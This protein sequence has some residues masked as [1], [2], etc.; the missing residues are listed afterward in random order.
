MVLRAWC[1]KMFVRLKLE[2]DSRLKFGSAIEIQKFISPTCLSLAEKILPFFKIPDLLP[3]SCALCIDLLKVSGIPATKTI[4]NAAMNYLHVIPM[5]IPLLELISMADF[6]VVGLPL[7]DPI[8]A[9]QH[10]LLHQKL[11]KISTDETRKEIKTVMSITSQINS[12]NNGELP[13]DRNLIEFCDF[14]KIVNRESSIVFASH[15]CESVRKSFYTYALE[16]NLNILDFLDPLLC[17]GLFD[18]AVKNI[19]L[20]LVASQFPSLTAVHLTNRQIAHL[21][22]IPMSKNSALFQSI[23]DVID[24]SDDFTLVCSWLRFMYHKE[25]WVRDEAKT[26]LSDIFQFDF[27][28]NVFNQPQKDFY[29]ETFLN[30]LKSSTQFSSNTIAESLLEIII[31]DDQ[32]IDIKQIS[33]TRLV[34][35]ILDPYQDL[36][37]IIPKLYNLSFIDFPD[38]LHAIS[39][40]DGN[41][42]IDKTQKL[43]ELVKLINEDNSIHLLPL[44]SRVIF[45]I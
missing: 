4:V 1:R 3:L 24:A 12:I 22:C 5:K 25:Q 31:S 45:K 17:A 16:H 13:V 21:Q 27:Q 11:S 34:D 44:L 18:P 38:L 6:E 29:V 20:E 30:K 39:I 10:P 15:P 19:A 40:R 23:T 14:S 8:L 36:R 2:E 26:I 35:L 32:P 7:L 28:L 33:A 37:N 41:Y 42:K 9:L 43:F